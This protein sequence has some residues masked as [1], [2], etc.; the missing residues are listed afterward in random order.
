MWPMLL[1]TIACGAIS[2]FHSLVSS[3]TTCKQIANESHA[4]RIGYGGMLTEGLVGVLVVI[5]VGAAL[6]REQLSQILRTGGPISAFSEGYGLMSAPLLGAYGKAFAVMALNAFILTT[7]DTATR[8]GRYLTAEIFGLTNKYVA[9]GIVVAFGAGLAL[10][11]Q[12]KYLWP[13][14]GTSNQ[15]I[16]ALALLVGSCW[17]LHRG[18]PFLYTLVPACI[19]LLTTLAAFSYQLYGAV[20]RVDK[21]G[22]SDPDLFIATVVVVLIVLALTVFWEGIRSLS[23]TRR[24]ANTPAVGVSET[25]GR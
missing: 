11:G 14:F 9:T 23:D 18:R 16:A 5:C 8:I 10:T 24:S 20:T 22:G 2:G 4:C 15:L 21:N 3:G 1:V 7:L 17:L 13:A 6:G 19:M 25:I 12:W